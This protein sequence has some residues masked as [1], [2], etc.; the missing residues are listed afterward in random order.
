MAKD[1]KHRAQRHPYAREPS[2]SWKWISACAALALLAV[3]FYLLG[4]SDSEAPDEETISV[5]GAAEIPKKP[6][7]APEPV[8]E[9][10]P[11]IVEEKPRFEF[12]RELLKENESIVTEQEIKTR[13]REEKRGQ[14]KVSGN[15]MVQ[16]GSFRDVKQADRMKAQLALLGIE[17]QIETVTIEGQTWNRVK[18]GPYSNVATAD[19]I[20]SRLKQNQIESRIFRT[21]P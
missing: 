13:K 6:A 15:F 20:R 4:T 14:V 19:K 5:E 11:K 2:T 9:E 21:S 16:A 3:V 12:Y 17:A 18:V 10:E 1:Y 8:T 7:E